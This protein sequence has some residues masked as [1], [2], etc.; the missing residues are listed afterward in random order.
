[1]KHNVIVISIVVGMIA[2]ALAAVDSTGVVAAVPERVSAAQRGVKG[3]NSKPNRQQRGQ[4]S[5]KPRRDVRVAGTVTGIRHCYRFAKTA[6]EEAM[7][8]VG[9][10]A[11]PQEDRFVVVSIDLPG[12]RSWAVAYQK[13]NPTWKRLQRVL[14]RNV[15]LPSIV[16]YGREK[17]VYE[18]PVEVDKGV[19]GGFVN[20]S[21]VIVEQRDRR[22]RVNP[23]Q[24]VAID[25]RHVEVRAR[26]ERVAKK[27]YCFSCRASVRRV[28][29]N[30]VTF[31]NGREATV[32][33]CVN[34]GAGVYRT[35][36]VGT[37]IVPV[38]ALQGAAA[39]AAVPAGV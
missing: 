17:G 8:A 7:Y 16:V 2:A 32:G 4:P 33:G 20:P 1:M 39:K 9:V 13:D 23:A 5:G 10:A 31:A 30:D 14:R 22:G 12:G 24:N 27:G 3:A 21:F 34:C 37:E 38:V 29:A 18:L 6:I 26:V 36:A 25:G 15:A 11:P 35:G 28:E 19:S